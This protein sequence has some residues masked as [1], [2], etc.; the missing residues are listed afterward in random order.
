MRMHS[1]RRTIVGAVFA[2][3]GRAA[4]AD[5][6]DAPATFR[7]LFSRLVESYAMDAIEADEVREEIAAQQV[8]QFLA[9]IVAAATERFAAVDEAE[10]LRLSGSELAGGALVAD[11]RVIAAVR[12]K[13]MA[14]IESAARDR[15]APCV[16]ERLA[17]VSE[18]LADRRPLFESILWECGSPAISQCGQL[19]PRTT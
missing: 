4:G 13:D 8:K 18:S 2:I 17:R 9:E 16:G 11:G 7:K 3:N 12:V 6:F 15:L 14:A 5:F 10:D 1:R 19:L